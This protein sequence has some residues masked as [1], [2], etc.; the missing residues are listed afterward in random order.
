MRIVTDG[1][2]IHVD[3]DPLSVHVDDRDSFSASVEESNGA[4]LIRLTGR[5]DASALPALEGAI[6]AGPHRDLV[7][8]L[9]ALTFMDGAAWVALTRLENRVRNWGRDLRLVNAHGR[10]RTIFELTG[11]EHLLSAA[12]GR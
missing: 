8:D 6:G 4:C 5:F 10:I 1:L 11:T 7:L 9:E 3:A 2:S 12:A